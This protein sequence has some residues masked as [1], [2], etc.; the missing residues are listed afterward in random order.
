MIVYICMI[1]LTVFFGVCSQRRMLTEDNRLS[2]DF[3]KNDKDYIEPAMSFMLIILFI[4]VFVSG[5]QSGYGDTTNYRMQFT[6]LDMTFS[7]SL[8][9]A[10]NNKSPFFTM[11]MAFIKTFTD[12]SQWL[13]LIVALL[14]NFFVWDIM[15]KYSYSIP[16]ACYYYICSGLF[17]WSMNGIR[18]CLVA[19]FLFFCQKLIL[20]GKFI[21]WILLLVFCY[22]FHTSAIFMIPVYFLFRGK[23]W[24]KKTYIFVGLILII[25]VFYSRFSNAFFDA[26]EGT[27]FGEYE[28]QVGE[29]LSTGI[30]RIAFMMIPAILSF[31]FKDMIEQENS[32]ML[33]MAVNASIL[34]AGIYILAGIGAGNLIGRIAF[35]SDL[36]VYIILVPYLLKKLNNT[37]YKIVVDLYI[38]VT[39]VFY[40]YQLKDMFWY[41][42]WLKWF[43]V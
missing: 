3:P 1:I 6:N 16:I 24:T 15:R 17:L 33:N 14:A 20:D 27:R 7:E 8:S 4:F 36:Y 25:G 10:W 43:F 5:L 34:S 18:Q 38:V 41:S 22:F 40:L 28:S 13:L 26:A 21:K 37:Q 19:T 32:P 12:D 30:P 42:Y 39:A 31:I 2:S 29:I 11:F 23:P 35:Y 9:S